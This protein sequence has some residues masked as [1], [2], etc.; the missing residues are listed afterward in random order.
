MGLAGFFAGLYKSLWSDSFR[1][2]PTMDERLKNRVVHFEIHAANP[3][4][5]VTFYAG[6]FGWKIQRWE[7]PVDYWVVTTGPMEQPGINGGIVRRRGPAPEDGQAV[8]SYVCTVQVESVDAAMQKIAFLG[9]TIVLPKM[10]VPGVGWLAYA[11][12]PD[13]NIFGIMHP[14]PAAA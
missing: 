5:V 6:L 12:D 9:G 4:R 11:K 13:G 3:E 10:P 8:N 7:G 14:D 1:G 2:G